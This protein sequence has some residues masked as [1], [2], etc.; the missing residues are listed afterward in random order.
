MKSI[1]FI[2]IIFCLIL[3]FFSLNSCKDKSKTTNISSLKSHNNKKKYKHIDT[4]LKRE[5]ISLYLENDKIII[6]NTGKLVQKFDLVKMNIPIK[7]IELVWANKKYACL[8]TWWSLNQSRH[9]FVPLDNK[10][11]FIYYDK[12]I[13][14]LDNFPSNIV[15]IDSTEQEKVIFQLK[16]LTK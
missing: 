4:L 3:I 16:K 7:T 10:N 12:D 2:K 5:N 1:P 14:E 6:L 9:I 11:K 8:V 13:E 15:D